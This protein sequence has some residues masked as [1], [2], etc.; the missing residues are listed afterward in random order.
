MT[1]PASLDSYTTSTS[2]DNTSPKAY[3]TQSEWDELNKKVNDLHEL[4]T[5]LCGFLEKLK[6]NPLLAP[7]MKQFGI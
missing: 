3:V 6:D 5:S 7:Y 4:G 2:I 1:Y